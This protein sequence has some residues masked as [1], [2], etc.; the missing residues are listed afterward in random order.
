MQ[1]EK[2]NDSWNPS[3]SDVNEENSPG[4]LHKNC[5]QTF[6]QC[7]LCSLQELAE[8]YWNGALGAMTIAKTIR[9][10]T[11]KHFNTACANDPP[12]DQGEDIV[13]EFAAL[14]GAAEAGSGVPAILIG[15]NDDVSYAEVFGLRLRSSWTCQDCGFEHVS[16][17]AENSDLAIALPLDDPEEEEED[18]EFYLSYQWNQELSIRCDRAACKAKYRREN[19]APNAEGPK[20]DR[21][22]RIIQAPQIL[23]IKLERFR[24]VEMQTVDEDGEIIITDWAQQKVSNYVP[25]PQWL[26][27]NE[28]AQDVEDDCLYRLDGVVSHGS[29]VIES[30]HYVASVRTYEGESFQHVEDDSPVYTTNNGD[31]DEMQG[32]EDFDPYILVYSRM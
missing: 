11:W 23:F 16:A 9:K 5:D 32:P 21:R 3:H 4:A 13:A 26:D 28:Y 25:F 31:F 10:Q 6:E 8:V 20:R 14:R 27:L 18:L 29:E 19:L 22:T 2:T 1:A 7:V 24:M 30:G 15:A 17:P 12:K